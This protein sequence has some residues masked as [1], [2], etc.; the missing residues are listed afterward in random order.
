MLYGDPVSDC[1]AGRMIPGANTTTQSVLISSLLDWPAM[2]VSIITSLI[3]L[4]VFS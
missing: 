4:L 2:G 3:F 1:H